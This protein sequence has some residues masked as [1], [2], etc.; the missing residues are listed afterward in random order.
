MSMPIV[1]ATVDVRWRAGGRQ[2]V[3][4]GLAWPP[5]RAALLSPAEPV[6]SWQLLRGLAGSN[7]AVRLFG[8]GAKGQRMTAMGSPGM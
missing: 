5:F 7:D 6:L 4:R 2:V 8:K 1:R 3:P